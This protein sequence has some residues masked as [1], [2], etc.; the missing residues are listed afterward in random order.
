MIQPPRRGENPAK[1][2]HKAPVTPDPVGERRRPEP[3]DG[4]VQTSAVLADTANNV[5]IDTGGLD[6]GDMF[7]QKTI[8]G[9]ITVS[10]L[11]ADPHTGEPVRLDGVRVRP[12]PGTALRGIPEGQRFVL[13]CRSYNAFKER[14]I[15]QMEAEPVGKKPVT[16]NQSIPREVK[17]KDPSGG[18]GNR[19][20]P[21]CKR[22]NR[23]ENVA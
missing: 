16:Q 10:L 3:P 7:S 14:D 20:T 23:M 8:T 12:I 17:Y 21:A 19:P 9:D 6:L 13:R 1:D 15:S 11:V 18:F 5:L 4:E 22:Y 2:S